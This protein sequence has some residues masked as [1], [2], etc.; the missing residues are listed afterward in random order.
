MKAKENLRKYCKNFNTV[1][2]IQEQNFNNVSVNPEVDD[3]FSFLLKIATIPIF[4]SPPFVLVYFLRD[5][6][7]DEFY[8][9]VTDL[10]IHV[11]GSVIWP[12]TVY[13]QNGKLRNYAWDYLNSFF[14][15][16]DD[17]NLPM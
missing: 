14:T 16:D 17:N 2:I 7:V 3:S 5:P 11:Y 13:I 6:Q 10:S 15:S 1:G 8:W 9:F 12:L 4:M